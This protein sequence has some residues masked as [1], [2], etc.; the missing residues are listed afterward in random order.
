MNVV[1]NVGYTLGDFSDILMA[2]GNAESY[3][4]LGLLEFESEPTGSRV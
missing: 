3:F 4:Q 1:E 2:L